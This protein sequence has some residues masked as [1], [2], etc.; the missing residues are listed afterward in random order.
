MIDPKQLIQYVIKPA[1]DV[2]RLDSLAAQQLL[3][4]TCAVESA[5][6]KYIHQLGRGPACGI[7][8]MEPATHTDIYQNFLKYRRRD[9]L[10]GRLQVLAGPSYRRDDGLYPNAQKMV[11]DLLYA[12][13]MARIFYLRVPAPLPEA[14][15]ISGMA[16]YWKRYYNTH[17]GAGTPLKYERAWSKYCSKAFG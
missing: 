9:E 17:L 3:L 4:G 5:C 1:L 8:Q 15:D 11:T 12:A 2:I 16:K 6:G 14:G 7:F 10:A 13:A